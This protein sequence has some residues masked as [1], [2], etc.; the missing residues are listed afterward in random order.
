MRQARVLTAARM[1]CHAASSPDWLGLPPAPVTVR[2]SVWAGG[3]GRGGDGLGGR[4]LGGS[5]SG[6]G[7]LGGG[8][9]G[10][11]GG[12]KG[13]EGEGGDGEGGGGE[14]QRKG[15]LEQSVGVRGEVEPDTL[16]DTP[17]GMPPD[18]TKK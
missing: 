16:N 17:Q 6:G 7:G 3:G 10:D 14:Q 11:G 5:G 8:G 2:A 4:G 18:S 12:G 15:S 1:A 13:G 9:L